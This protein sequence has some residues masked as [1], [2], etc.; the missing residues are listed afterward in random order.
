ME[1]I[2]FKVDGG[3]ITT[4][5]RT[6]FWDENKPYEICEEL[7]F[8]CLGGTE[9]TRDEL[10]WIVQQILEGR[11][12]L[13]GINEFELIDDN[14]NIRPLST[15]INNQFRKINIERIRTDM[16]NY[17]IAYVDPYSTVKSIKAAKQYDVYTFEQCQT[18]FWYSDSD[19]DYRYMRP[20]NPGEN[21][22]LEEGDDTNLGLWLYLYPDIVYDIK[23]ETDTTPSDPDFWN[24]LYEKI[25]DDSRFQSKWFK[26]RNENY[27]AVKRIN[28]KRKDAPDIFAEDHKKVWMPVNDKIA[29]VAQP[30]IELTKEWLKNHP[31]DK[32]ADAA[33]QH[34]HHMF[35]MAY[36]VLTEHIEAKTLT[37]S[38]RIWTLVPDDYEEWEGLISPNGD[39]YSC[40]FGGHNAKAY[41]LL[42]AYPEKFPGIDYDNDG[43]KSIDID[44]ALDDLLKQRWCATRYLPLMGH[45]IELPKTLRRECTKAQINAIFDAKI[46]HDVP[47]DLSAIGY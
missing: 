21:M 11:K 47:V 4:I 17:M 18:W 39:F 32:T 43:L 31:F 6:W 36:D 14:E 40:D 22:L 20:W 5:A 23:S 34:K 24:T 45:F 3:F 2:A 44:N 29:K 15:K 33:Y 12:K 8:N 13:V 38:D 26:K 16:H 27:L 30:T 1:R 10:K 9:S 46:K 19:I 7:L 41:H 28:Q 37:D 35:Q 25:K 42:M